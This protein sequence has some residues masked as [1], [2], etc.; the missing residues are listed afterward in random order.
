MI[1]KIIP[2]AFKT[3]LLASTLLLGV[4]SCSRGPL[5]QI[6]GNNHSIVETVDKY[7]KSNFNNSN[8]D[9]LEMYKIDTIELNKNEL[10]NFEG[11]NEKL[12]KLAK[13]RNPRVL[14]DERWEYGYA[15]GP[16]MTLSGTKTKSGFDYHKVEEYADKYI[17]STVIGKIQN[18]VFANKNESRFFVP[19]EYY[20]KLD[21]A[22]KSI[23][24]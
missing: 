20:G 13:Y 19:V 2:N 14:V 24:D 15:I 8:T 10:E 5:H 12:N 7:A 11:F 1:T 16:R 9:N 4:T 17:D 22:V 21:S 3:T 6:D 18:K 23:K